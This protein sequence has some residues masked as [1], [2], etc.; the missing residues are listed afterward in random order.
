METLCTYLPKRRSTSDWFHVTKSCP[1]MLHI[2]KIKKGPFV[3][4]D[5]S[6]RLQTVS[7]TF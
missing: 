2:A 7:Q 4:Y 5:N 3:T 6:A 1:Y